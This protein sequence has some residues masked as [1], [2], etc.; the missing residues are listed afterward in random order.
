MITYTTNRVLLSSA[1]FFGL[2]CGALSVFD[3]CAGQVLPSGGPPDTIPPLIIRSYPD[4][5]ATRIVPSHIELEFSEYVDRRTAEE[6]VFISPYV[7]QL[8][9]DWSGTEVTIHFGEELRKSTTYVVTVGTDISDL[10]ARGGNK[11]AH[12]YTL[13]FSTGDSIDRGMISGRVFD[14]HPDGVMIFAYNLRD[15][16]PDTLDPTHTRP[17]Y[18]MQTGKDG[19]FGLRN[20]AFGTYRVIA[21]RDEYRNLLYDREIDQFGVATEDAVV[22]DGRPEVRGVWFRLSK[23][24]TTR[25]FLAS[26]SAVDSKH[27]LVRFSEPID[28]LAFPRAVFSL[29]DTTSKAG[30]AIGAQYQSMGN[31][32]LANIETAE[33]MDSTRA[34]RL[35]VRGILDR[36]GNRLDTNN[37]LSAFSGP[38]TPDT[39]KPYPIVRAVADSARALALVP[40]F[41]MDFRRPVDLST[42]I[43]GIS[44]RD[45]SARTVPIEVR[46]RTPAEVFVFPSTPLKSFAWYTFRVSLDSLRDSRGVH[47]H[48]SLYTL[49][50]QTLDSRLLGTIEGTLAGSSGG[51]GVVVSARTTDQTP[52]RSFEIRVDKPGKFLIDQLPEGRYRIDAF[53]DLDGDGRFRAGLPH[54][55]VPS[56]PFTVYPDTVKVRARWSVEGV[57]VKFR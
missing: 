49:R 34:Y 5:N 32:A 6:A 54:P 17:Q 42:A 57:Q 23:E 38:S 24:D 40:V 41:E 18:I 36:A 28:T 13:A 29:S 55:F 53:E 12:A 16:D 45:S 30:L 11:M 46:P 51:H 1:F 43:H 27:L 7:G 19:T 8:E 2:M 37:A 21:V 48:D 22:N 20:V 10:P 26:V 31:Q 4:S 14:E 56:A 39:I 3:G 15:V 33:S 25:P 50:F 9:F 35:A 52:Q 47:W 44:L